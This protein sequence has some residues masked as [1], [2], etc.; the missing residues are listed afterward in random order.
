MAE[1][2]ASIPSPEI[3]FFNNLG[4][5]IVKSLLE[6]ADLLAIPKDTVIL[7]RLFSSSVLCLSHSE[8]GQPISGQG[9]GQFET[10]V[11]GSE[12]RRR[13]TLSRSR[14]Q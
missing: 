2:L 3:F 10:N 12:V 9:G 4:Q 13:G 8:G 1:L 7:F 11:L 14:L 5:T 6:R